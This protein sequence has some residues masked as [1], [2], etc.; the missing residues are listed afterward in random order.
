M[1]TSPRLNATYTIARFIFGSPTH[2][3][4][5]AVHYSLL[6]RNCRTMLR[7]LRKWAAH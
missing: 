5:I 1:F 4:H 7:S 2:L 3:Q 6:D